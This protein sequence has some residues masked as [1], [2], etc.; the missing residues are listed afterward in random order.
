MAAMKGQGDDSSAFGPIVNDLRCFI[1][2]MPHSMINL[3]QR[4]GNEAAHRLARMG[5]SSS[6]EYVWFEELPDLIQVILVEEGL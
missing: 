2:G 5:L 4:E 6:Q 1:A 3:A